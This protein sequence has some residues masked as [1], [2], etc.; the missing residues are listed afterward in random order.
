ML[1]V[2]WNLSPVTLALLVTVT[3]WAI[4]RAWDGYRE[5]VKKSAAIEQIPGPR[6]PSVLLGHLGLL[7]QKKNKVDWFQRK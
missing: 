2:L 3:M 6:I 7:W 4:A 1:Y 5:L